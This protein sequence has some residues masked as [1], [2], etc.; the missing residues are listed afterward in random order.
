MVK[1]LKGMRKYFIRAVIMAIVFGVFVAFVKHP[2]LIEV[3]TFVFIFSIYS[4]SWSLM[5]NS[6]QIS[7]GHAVFFGSGAYASTLIARNLGVPP[8]I[9]VLVG[10]LVTA[11]IGLGIGRLCLGLREW[12]LGMVTFGFSIIAQLIVVEQLGWLTKGWD[13]IS[14]P[15][16]LPEE[17]PLEMTPTLNYLI[18]LAAMIGTYLVVAAVMQSRI[19][20]AFLAMH[21]NELVANVYGVNVRRYRLLAFTLGGYLAGLAGSINSHTL[22]RYLSPE[23]YHLENSIWPLLYSIAGGVRIVEGP[24]LGTLVIRLFW[25]WMVR[26]IGGFQAMLVIGLFLAVLVIFMPQGIFAGLSRAFQKPTS[27][28]KIRR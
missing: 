24:I 15:R 1:A 11:L 10:P 25:E 18:A 22:T 21:D 4:L 14:V 5:A 20:L 12:F 3:M 19:G 23:I 7:L 13:G 28:L 17:V 27:L 9:A 2:F 8:P 16:I 6:G 26:Y